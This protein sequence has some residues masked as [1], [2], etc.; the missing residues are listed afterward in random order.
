[1]PVEG[2]KVTNNKDPTA[3]DL[4][5]DN[6]TSSRV[7][8]NVDACGSSCCTPMERAEMEQKHGVGNSKTMTTILAD[9]ISTREVDDLLK[10]SPITII[11][12]FTRAVASP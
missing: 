5:I 9:D 10:N 1:M 2:S 6:F 7:N 4:H 12:A 8:D 3:L 11:V